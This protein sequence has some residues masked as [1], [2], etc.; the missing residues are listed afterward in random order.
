MKANFYEKYV[1]V[2]GG[3]PFPNHSHDVDPGTRQVIVT[4][5]KPLACCK[6]SM[7]Y[8]PEGQEHYPIVGT[9]EFLGGNQSIKL[10]VALKPAWHY[11]F[12]LTDLSFASTNGFPLE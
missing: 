7:N 8:G 11:S 1:H 4:F 10:S 5:D 2:A 12:T 6:Y 3:A 9:P